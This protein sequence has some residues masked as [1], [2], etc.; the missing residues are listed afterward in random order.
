MASDRLFG[1]SLTTP[2]MAAAVSDTAWLAALLRFEA[3]LA[4]AE[5]RLGIIPAAA[6]QSIVASCG[7]ERFDVA[8]IGV[9][10]VSSASPVVPLVDALRRLVGKSAAEY[11]HHGAT[12][13][14]ALDT[15]MMLVTRD[16]L[17]VLLADLSRL[18]G[19][20]A[21]LARRHRSDPMNGRT[22]MQRALPITFGLKSANW[23]VGVLEARDYL[24]RLRRDRLAVQL[25]G[26]V[27]TLEAFGER[28]FD[29]V[30][31]LA[32][33]LDLQAPAVPWHTVRT[34]IGE[35]AAGLAL[36]AGA[37]AKVALD[38]VLMA[39]SEVGEVLEASPGR[40]SSMPHKQNPAHA[41][42]ARAAFAGAI[43]Q[44]GVL[45]GSI[46]GEHERAAGSWQAEWPALTEAFRLTAGAVNR[47]TEAVTGLRVDTARMRENLPPDQRSAVDVGLADAIIDRALAMY[48]KEESE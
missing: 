31:A 3:A 6:A 47:A 19:Q 8:S 21:S 37:A 23:L 40:S 30:E 27:G 34:R 46:P 36:A 41:V 1:P 13:Q 28:G 26:A 14:D 33:E 11:V 4:V 43:A 17:G 39:Q 45:L 5:S 22:L 18:A 7:F 2:A 42:E 44:A 10:A 16:A 25:G 35:L 48:S 15:A 29:L 32:N 24:S 9:A 12:S 38:I 20:C